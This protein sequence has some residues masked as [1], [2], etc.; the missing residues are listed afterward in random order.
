MSER[1]NPLDAAEKVRGL[2]NLHI[3]LGAELSRRNASDKRG[4]SAPQ[5]PV[6][7]DVVDARRAIEKLAHEYLHMLMDDLPDFTPPTEIPEG[8][9]TIAMRIGHFTHHENSLVAWDFV[10]SVEGVHE[11]AERVAH[12]DGMTWVP[13]NRACYVDECAGVLRVRVDR[14]K[15]H[16]ERSLALWQPTA[17]CDMDGGHRLLA[18]LMRDAPKLDGAA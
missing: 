4:S 7:L 12:P 1:P 8:L 16:D 17:V 15:P 6:D 5:V 3:E 13:I 10:E 18:R 11:Q 14:D 9:R 2:A